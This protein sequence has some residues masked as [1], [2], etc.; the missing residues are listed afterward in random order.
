MFDL[1]NVVDNQTA[2]EELE[3]VVMGLIINSGQAR[4]LAYGAPQKSERRR[5]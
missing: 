5:F 2:A 3:E 4:S 1:E